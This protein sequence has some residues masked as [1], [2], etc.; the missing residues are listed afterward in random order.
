MP[1]IGGLIGALSGYKTY[2]TVAAI[3]GTAIAKAM[4]WDVPDWLWAVYGAAGLG[5]VR[6]AVSKVGPV[7]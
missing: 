2:L 5:S 7:K 1:F 6:E 4:G 3:A